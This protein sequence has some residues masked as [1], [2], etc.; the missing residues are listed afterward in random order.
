MTPHTRISKFPLLL[1]CS[2]ISD[3][4]II[5]VVCFYSKPCGRIRRRLCLVLFSPHLFFCSVMFCDFVHAP[6]CAV[7]ARWRCSLFI[8]KERFSLVPDLSARCPPCLFSLPSPPLPPPFGGCDRG[9]TPLVL[10]SCIP[11]D[12][13]IQRITI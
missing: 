9:A 13:R 5:P 4:C 8:L 10:T 1:E 6:G 11:F 2:T 3:L 12:V 7:A